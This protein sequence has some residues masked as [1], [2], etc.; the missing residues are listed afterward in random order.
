M[1]AP[2]GLEF[3]AKV[4]KASRS[5]MVAGPG[6][7]LYAP[8]F[9]S[10]EAVVGAMVSGHTELIDKFKR[11]FATQTPSLEV[12][13]QIACELLGLEPGSLTKA[14]KIE[15]TIG[16]LAQ[17]SFQYGARRPDVWRN[18]DPN[19]ELTDAEIMVIRSKWVGFN[20]PIDRCWNIL[21]NALRQ[22]ILRPGE[23]KAAG[24]FL[25]VWYDPDLKVLY[26]G[27]PNGRRLAYAEPSL[28]EPP[29]WGNKPG[30]ACKRMK[31][32]AWVAV[33]LWGGMLFENVVQA[34]SRD[35]LAEAMLRLD[36]AGYVIVGHVHDEIILEIDNASVVPD[37]IGIMTTPPEWMPELPLSVDRSIVPA[38]RFD[39]IPNT[40]PIQYLEDVGLGEDEE[41]ENWDEEE[42]EP[43]D[44]PDDDDP[45]G[46]EPPEEEVEDEEEDGLPPTA[47]QLSNL[48]WLKDNV[49][50]ECLTGEE[51]DEDHKIL[52]SFHGD[53]GR[54]NMHIYADHFHCYQCGAHGDHIDWLRKT[55]GMGY[56]EAF[57]ELKKWAVLP[58]EKRKQKKKD[59]GATR[60]R[61]DALWA[62]CVPL[63]DT[64][65]EAYLR[66]E[67]KIDVGALEDKIH[68]VL[69]YLENCPLPKMRRNCVVARWSDSVTPIEVGIHRISITK[70]PE[71]KK[72]MR[73]SL[74]RWP[75]GVRTIKFWVGEGAGSRTLHIAEGV[76]TALA[77]GSRVTYRGK[78]MWPIWAVGITGIRSLPLVEGYD[79]LV[80]LAENDGAK[81]ISLKAAMKTAERWMRAGRKVW[82]LLPKEGSDFNDITM[83]DPGGAGF[84]DKY[85]AID[86]AKMPRTTSVVDEDDKR[87]PYAT[88]PET[89]ARKGIIAL[90]NRHLGVSK[91]LEPPMRDLDGDLV[92]KHV[93]QVIGMHAF[94]ADKEKEKALPPPDRVMLRKMSSE[95]AAETIEDHIRFM[96]K[97]GPGGFEQ[98]VP[99][100]FVRH[101][102]T[103][104]D[105]TALPRVAGIGTLPIVLPN[106]DVLAQSR[107]LHRGAGV[108]FHIPE[109]IIGNLPR[110]GNCGP[111]EVERAWRF[112][113]EGKPGWLTDVAT[114]MEGRAVLIAMGLTIIERMLMPSRPVFFVTAGQSGVGKTTASK[115]ILMATT[116]TEGAAASW[117]P[118]PVERGKQVFSFFLAGVEYILWDNI[119]LTEKIT[120]PHI[121][122]SCTSYTYEDRVLGASRILQASACCVHI[123]TGNNIEPLGDL[124]TRALM[125]RITVE[126]H[127]PWNRAFQFTDPVDW[128]HQNRVR[129]LRALYTVLLGNP[130]LSSALDAP[131]PTRFKMWQRMVGNA[132]E[133]AAGLCGQTIRFD[134]AFERQTVLD[135]E[136]TNVRQVLVIF[137]RQFPNG[138]TAEKLA[139]FIN[140]M[141]S[142]I[143]DAAV[144]REHL[145][146]EKEFAK[147]NQRSVGT[148]L[149]KFVDKAVSYEGK[150]LL[151][152]REEDPG[153]REAATYR[154]KEAA[155]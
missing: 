69:R 131:M 23:K 99:G 26:I 109:Q 118:S 98:A 128:T 67:R 133:H 76:E 71:E 152:K 41:A 103:R 33:R 114:D 95:E 149:G 104:A 30:I 32:G 9:E 27:L 85:T 43:D 18:F 155:G 70:A 92:K 116:G 78:P 29:P 86:A 77:A 138:F 100:V 151:L 73:A 111:E 141:V 145:Y 61:A 150:T 13:C 42:I 55:R 101:F 62:A 125:T 21:E 88:P 80:I 40:P 56:V 34:I 10:I 81:E 105:D 129:I 142:E 44:D 79:E 87:P 75:D 126:H 51:A 121:E 102:M 19:S 112:L 123:F 54:P 37:I 108:L 113:T 93:G 25:K 6:K 53:S 106:G 143:P 135:E 153:R 94:L 139:I 4:A 8:D 60:K 90:F 68:D 1:N 2:F 7:L 11:Y 35:V 146:P 58:R 3:Q 15:R 91:A 59:D 45:D 63:K 36:R 130:A 83:A 147:I 82:I 115:M 89:A 144:I 16:K 127:K 107:G 110:R 84:E 20:K 48:G 72:R 148:R 134:E 57:E 74:G 64:P 5:I 17:L 65:G 117:N 31:K 66:D 96:S 119:P 124:A 50:L 120:C 39:K 122:R 38:P 14:N 12:Y 46:G 154:V 132:V 140:P 24:A 137:M 97:L 22:A 49:S 52:C 28:T 136:S 47:E